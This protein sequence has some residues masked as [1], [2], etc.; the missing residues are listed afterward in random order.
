MEDHIQSLISMG[1]IDRDLNRKLLIKANNDISEAV[2][3][4]TSYNYFNDD[5][6][7][8]H[9]PAEASTASP[10]I[11]PLASEQFEQEQP[12]HHQQQ[13]TVKERERKNKKIRD[14]EKKKKPSRKIRKRKKESNIII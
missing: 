10:F 7:D 1:F 2:T 8:V 12:L 9:I 14:I 5:D 6:D 13:Q 4:L 3:L 11:S